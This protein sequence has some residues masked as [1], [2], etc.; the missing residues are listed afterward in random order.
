LWEGKRD[1]ISVKSFERGKKKKKRRKGV[2][3]FTF[4]KEGKKK[5][6]PSRCRGMTREKGGHREHSYGNACARP[7]RKRKGAKKK[8]EPPP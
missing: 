1:A 3:Y 5:G 6:S 8:G 4:E 2:T 7:P